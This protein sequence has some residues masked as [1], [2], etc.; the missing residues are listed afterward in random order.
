MREKDIFQDL[1]PSLEMEYCFTLTGKAEL[2][3]LIYD[4]QPGENAQKDLLSC[5]PTMV[6]NVRPVWGKWSLPIL[7]R[8]LALILSG[9]VSTPRFS[10]LLFVILYSS[11]KGQVTRMSKYG[12]PRSGAASLSLNLMVAPSFLCKSLQIRG[13]GRSGITRK[14]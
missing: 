12:L 11:D 13:Y 6:T 2:Q 7:Q 1:Y 5:S 10:V 3:D 14:E 4:E 8:I 9:R